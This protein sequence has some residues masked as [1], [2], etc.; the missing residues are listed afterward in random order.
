MLRHSA[1]IM[2][3]V[4]VLTLAASIPI[5]AQ[6]KGITL[7]SLSRRIDILF[8]GQQYSLERIVALETAVAEYIPPVDNR[9][10]VIATGNVNVRQGPGTE[11]PIIG[12]AT[13]GQILPSEGEDP[14]GIWWQ[15]EF[16][17][18][19]GWIHG[20]YLEIFD[21]DSTKQPETPT[22]LRGN[23]QATTPEPVDIPQ[24]TSRT[25]W[26]QTADLVIKDF[27][28]RGFEGS[29]LTPEALD[30][31]INT[32]M[33]TAIE[34][35][36]ECEF[37]VAEL[38][39]VVDHNADRLDQTDIPENLDISPRWDLISS[40]IEH[41]HEDFSCEVNLQGRVNWIIDEY[42]EP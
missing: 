12:T 15:V 35:A 22:P 6:Q 37:E 11:H 2:L 30:E 31:V 42:S 26:I 23:E 39:N 5:Y 38:L 14:D 16:D 20:F 1:R 7:E 33:Q 28:S 8:T 19:T 13:E 32:Y 40:L 25:L 10:Q 21:P 29:Y 24:G 3:V 36:D 18:Q 4:A 17:G 34:A 9:I 41:R 27:K